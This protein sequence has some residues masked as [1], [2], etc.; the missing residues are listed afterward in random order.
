MLAV[1]AAKSRTV[2]G[3]ERKA[4]GLYLYSD[5]GMYRLTPKG[6]RTVRVTYTQKESFEPEM[7]PGIVDASVGAWDVH[8]TD[9]TIELCA[10]EVRV[11]IDRATAAFTY[12]GADGN[13]LLA[14]RAHDSKEL[15]QFP[16]YRI[17]G[18][19]EVMTEKIATA[20][21]EKV[22][23]RAADRVQDGF[24]YHTRLWLSWQEKEALYGLG[25]HEEGFFDLRGQMVFLHQGNRRIA[26]PMLLSS[27]G[28]GILM[29]TYSPMVFSDTPYGSYLYTEADREM[30]FYFMAGGSMDGVVRE[31]RRLTGKAALLPKWA[32]G[33]IQ[34]Q[35]RYETQEEI[36]S[37]A[38][39]YRRRGLG[40]DAIVLD[41]CSWEDGQWGQKSFD[42]ARF[43]DPSAMTE[44][45]HGKNV[46]FMM[47]IWPNMGGGCENRREFEERGLLLPGSEIYDAFSEEGRAL[48]W[49]QVERA[50]YSRGVDSWWCDSSEPFTP[51]WNRFG[52][53]EPAALYAEYC[54][55]M[56]DYMPA[57]QTNAFCLYHAR[58]LWEG[59]RG[60]RLTQQNE[61]RVMNLTRSGYTGQQRYGTVLWSGDIAASWDTFRR[62]IAAGLNFCACGL[63]YW[64]T[65]I[66]AFFVKKGAPWYWGGDYPDTT[67]DCGYR[68]LYV[69]WFEWACFLPVFRGH[70]TDCRREIW[71]FGEAGTP[72]YDALVKFNR[73]RYELMP[74][75]YSQAG[76]VWL[77]DDS[78]IRL[79][80]FAFPE[81]T[82]VYSVADQYL[83]GD[84]IMVCPVTEPMYYDAVSR[85]AEGAVCKRSVYLPKGAGWYD[86]WTNTYYE[87]GQRIAA[88]APLD[89]IPLYV[90]AGSILATA[91][92]AQSAAESG[93][94]LILRI[95]E[96][97]E[98][99]CLY[100][101]DAGD[102]YGYERGEY[103]LTRFVWEEK[104]GALTSELAAGAKEYARAAVV[105]TVVIRKKEGI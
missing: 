21:G 73:L 80:V 81:D 52:R 74:Y 86:Y 98:N 8:E 89:R 30:D 64:T 22:V 47:S 70:G 38:D 71:Q 57:W 35:E 58:C 5:A 82:Q 9:E 16:V 2:T 101:E 59:Q 7:K 65:D 62:Q 3:L 55:E 77:C 34:S 78:F 25:Q 15:E 90:R 31:Y 23:V 26:V 6:S 67:E 10:G 46:H 44:E 88:D 95:Y 60:S 56:G 92:P 36:L 97:G 17:A 41:W 85:P 24:L 48:Y 94:A 18:G 104:R 20:D 1:V 27:L 12:C 93:D 28:Y 79:L 33:Y 76:K 43:P 14:E 39:E 99:S 11:R 102:G 45:L 19:G 32:F 49:Q 91:G 42:P 96:G 54:R 69:R 29:D 37:V 75:I 68:E 66:G 53:T 100:Y 83:F 72:F 61:K 40:L 63:P 84:S 51:E 13:V 4:D 87:G 50:L 103:A 105:E